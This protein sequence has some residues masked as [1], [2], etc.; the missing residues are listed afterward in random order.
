[1]THK[2]KKKRIGVLMGGISPEREISLKTGRAVL[3]SLLA[4]DY[5][6][7]GLD[8]GRSIAA[9]L[10]EEK[11]GVAFVA[12]HGPWGEDGTIQGLLEMMGIPY[13]G[14]G[15]LASALAMNKT[16]AKKVFSY[17]ELPTPEFQIVPCGHDS[18]KIGISLP[19]VAKPVCGGSTIGISIVNSEGELRD[20]LAKAAE[21]DQEIFVEHY[22]EG[23]DLTVGV[24][25]GEHLPVIEIV[26]KSGF[27][28]FEA[29]YSP[30]KTAY[31]VPARVPDDVTE[32][33]QN[34]AVAA[35]RALACAGAARVDFRMDRHGMLTILEVNTIPG[36]TER[37]L[38][39]MAAAESG[40]DFSALTERM[41]LAA[42]LHSSAK[43]RSSEGL[44]ACLGKGPE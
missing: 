29:K 44:E 34:L 13:T 32:K 23:R 42:S 14:S 7:I 39:P 17:H 41:L 21:Y 36:L 11:V 2:F 22:V 43:Q 28:D 40:I 15:V 16:M 9:R 19:L 33:A 26:P 38:L 18:M 35:Y 10:T 31:V 25:N 30:G 8:A 6:A 4:Q 20:A 24:L 3:K 1:M 37:S 27:Y 12:L 5:H